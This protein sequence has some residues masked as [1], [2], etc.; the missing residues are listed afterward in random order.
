MRDFWAGFGDRVEL[1]YFLYI[2]SPWWYT[3]RNKRTYKGEKVMAGENK[4]LRMTDLQNDFQLEPVYED[5]NF[6]R[7]F[8][9]IALTQNQK[10]QVSMALQHI[11]EL[12]DSAVIAK[13]Y[14]VEFPDGLQHS[15]MPL[16]QGGESAIWKNADGRFGGTASLYE[17][18]TLALV[19]G[20]FSAMAIATGQYF[21]TQI[22]SELQMLNQSTDKI[23]EFLYGDKK[24]ELLSEVSF[25][26]FAYDNYS[27]IMNHDQQRVATIASLQAAKKVA[28]K[29][30]E[31][32]MSDL[33][34]AVN[35]KDGIDGLV[36]NAFRIKESLELSMQ[37]YGLSSV[38]ETYF[39]QNYD[40]EF[41]KYMEHDV[42]VYIDKCEK[43]MLSSFSALKKHVGDYKAK[44]LE[45]V[46]K[47]Q[48]EKPIAELVDSLNNGEESGI[49]ASLRKTLDE[50]T[51]AKEYYVDNKGDVYLKTA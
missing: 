15:L 39:S 1:R 22:N 4:I 48:Y 28:M 14:R 32:Y 5:V 36:F 6:D 23:L 40:S 10:K 44:L 50:V 12:F 8:T 42:T 2:S 17:L 46:N 38:L 47:S 37:L 18:K 41:V 29:D 7:D 27:S 13:A 25:V 30:I 34:S 43:R 45:K 16:R 3:G 24:A 51:S 26:K 20:A 35:S 19:S 21:I 49:R 9:K 33:E 11:P 31:F